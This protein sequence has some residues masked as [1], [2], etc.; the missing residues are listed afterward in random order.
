METRGERERVWRRDVPRVP[1]APVRRITSPFFEA[2]WELVVEWVGQ[3]WNSA[4]RDEMM[5][6]TISVDD[7]RDS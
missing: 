6:F 5:L 7:G 3:D 2:G 1:E 4:S